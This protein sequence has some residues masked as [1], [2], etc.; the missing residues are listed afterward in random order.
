MAKSS[1]MISDE[2]E[3]MPIKLYNYACRD[4]EAWELFEDKELMIEI[5]VAEDDL[6]LGIVREY[7]GFIK[8][9]MDLEGYR[10]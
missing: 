4:V 7:R 5:E 6:R 1:M 10:L 8:G 2:D 9:V 3:E